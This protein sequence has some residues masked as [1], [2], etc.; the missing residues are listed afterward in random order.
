L[1]DGRRFIRPG[2]VLAVL[3]LVVP[4]G[5]VAWWLNRPKPAAGPAPDSTELDVVCLGR[6]DSLVPVASL[7]PGT[8]GRV[9]KVV[10]EG[11]VV[12]KDDP[13]LW[14]DDTTPKLRVE[15]AQAAVSAAAAERDAAKLELKLQPLRKTAQKAAVAAAQEKIDAAERLLDQRKSQQQFN[16][17]TPAELFAAEAE[18]R[19]LKQLKGAE[20][21]RLAELDAA[22]PGLK[23]R[24]TEAKLAAAEVAR[25]QADRAVAECVLRAPSGG[26]VLRVQTSPGEAVAP[27]SPQPP[28]VFRPNGPLVVRAELEQ[29]FLGRVRPGMKATVRDEFRPDAPAIGGTVSRVGQWVARKRAVVLEP[30]ELGDVRTVECVIG[31]DSPPPDLLVGQ[32][33]RVRIGRAD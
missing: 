2:W 6:I 28:I 13:L 1:S 16:M 7:D 9:V 22:D 23:V 24:A 32:R 31:L 26:V 12:T 3:L 27:G 8:P 11:A 18:V 14:L 29:E 15:E 25:R 20:E 33:V 10:A 21:A 5:A 17:V 4:V 19:Q 30:G